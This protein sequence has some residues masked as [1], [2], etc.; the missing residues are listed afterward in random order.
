M[1]TRKRITGIVTSDKMEKTVS[2]EISRKFR[3]PLY[4]KVVE[5]KR[6]VKAHDE[7][8]ARIG[9]EVVI[10]ESQPISKTKR[11]V[12]QEILTRSERIE[13]LEGEA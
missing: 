10:V 1:N 12:V 11:W 5:K 4:Q 9:D 2:V 13:D 3:H 8:G 6:R 7:L